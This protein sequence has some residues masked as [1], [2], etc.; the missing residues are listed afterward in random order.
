MGIR[1]KY[2]IYLSPT[3][4]VATVARGQGSR[5]FS[6]VEIETVQGVVVGRKN[7]IYL[8][9]RRRRFFERRTQCVGKSGII[10][11]T[12]EKGVDEDLLSIPFQEKALVRN[13]S[14]G[15]LTLGDRNHQQNG[16]K[17]MP[18]KPRSH[19]LS[20]PKVYVIDSK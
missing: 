18:A 19:K 1:W 13:I 5:D 3:L 17:K 7:H 11:N 9:K 8:I 12:L 2:C 10:S 16:H 15:D 4:F 14:N 6:K 20:R